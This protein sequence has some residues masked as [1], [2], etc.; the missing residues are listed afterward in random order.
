M[1]ITQLRKCIKFLTPA[2]YCAILS[3]MKLKAIES[4]GDVAFFV[5]LPLCFFILGGYQYE[6]S[7]RIEA[8]ESELKGKKSKDG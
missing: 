6:Q 4:T 8:L 7:K 5:F 1:N 3:V 2:L